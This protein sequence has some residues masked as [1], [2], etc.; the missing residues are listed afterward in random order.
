MTEG[1]KCKCGG[2]TKKVQNSRFTYE[3]YKCKSCG[4]EIHLKPCWNCGEAINNQRRSRCHVCG[5]NYCP[6]CGVCKKTCRERRV[7][8]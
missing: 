7:A 5:W 6:S 8:A 3:V 1:P 4:Y 2:A